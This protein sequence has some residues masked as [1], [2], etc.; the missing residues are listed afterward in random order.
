[1]IQANQGWEGGIVE[2]PS[3]IEDSGAFYLFYSGN[4]WDTA[5]YAIGY[6][7]CTSPLGPCTKASGPWLASSEKAQGP[8]GEEL[9]RDG[10]NNVWIALHAWVDGKVGYTQ[11]ARNL[12]V[13]KVAF[14][15]GAPVPA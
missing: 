12:F 9:F 15:N 5:S 4:R 14:E 8:G 3:M 11:G 13:L 1:L 6:A 2:A 7:T 10:S